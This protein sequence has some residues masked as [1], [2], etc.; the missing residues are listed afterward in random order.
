[1]CNNMRQLKYIAAFLALSLQ[2]FGQTNIQIVIKNDGNHKIDKVDVSD[3][4]QK[5]VFKIPY[6]DTLNFVFNKQNIDCYNIRYHENGKMYRQQIWLNSGQI[7]I[8]AH[9]D[10]SELQ[11]DSVYNSPIY[12]EHL[13]FRRNYPIL[14]KKNDTTAINKM[15]LELY[16]KNI[17]NPYSLLFANTYI[18]LNENSK[19]NLSKLKSLTDKQGERFNW[20]LIYPSVVERLNNILTVNSININDYTF[21]DRQNKNV[22]FTALTKKYYILDFWFL[23]CPPC[24]Q[25]HKE[26]KKEIKNLDYKNAELISISIDRDIVRWNTYLSKNK[27]NWQN[28]LESKTKKITENL[29]ISGYPTY[30]IIDKLGNI[31]STQNSFFNVLKWLDKE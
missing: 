23:D 14:Y 1:M 4:S 25:D 5:E 13:N 19:T 2:S 16:S 29:S 6:N 24:L 21:I 12:Y 30:I 17:D 11:I 18:Q 20:F 3:L 8:E 27:Y 28:Y 7:K 10:S 31:L 26:I 22:K 9:L 15:L